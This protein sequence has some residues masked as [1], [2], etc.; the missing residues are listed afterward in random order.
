MP[1]RGVTP[2]SGRR[3]PG[4]EGLRAL[5]ACSILVYHSWVYS[6]PKGNLPA[7]GP[8]GHV[9]P[10]LSFGVVL[11]FTLS[12]FLLFRPFAAAVIRG[13]PLPRVTTYLKNRA[14]RILP[15]YWVILALTAFL[16][17]A[18]LSRDDG[19]SNLGGFVSNALLAQNY[20][21]KTLGSGIGPAW[22][23]AVEAVFYA[24]LPLLALFALTAARKAATRRGRRMAALA[25]A[26][27][28]LALGLFGK[29]VAA[30][31]VPPVR[32]FDGWEADWHSVIERSFLC[33]AD[34]FAFGMA[35]A[36]VRIDA[37]DGLLRLP[38]GWR[39]IAGGG[40]LVAY[41]VTAKFTYFSQQLSYS[42]FN[43]L[44]AFAFALLLALVVL[45]GRDQSGSHALLRF[46]ETRPLVGAGLV[47]YSI[48]LWHEPL[49]RWLQEHHLTVDGGWGF[50]VNVLAA[51]LATA[52][53]ST[54]TY[55]FVEAPAMRLKLQRRLPSVPVAASAEAL[56]PRLVEVEPGPLYGAEPPSATVRPP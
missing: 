20:D 38:R 35:L 48:F 1:M 5:A 41:L 18:A 50:G 40:A 3:I 36:V 23:L 4:I 32:P 26:A 39:A 29:G 8:L 12:G 33:Q 22:S 56:V 11:F 31:L 42:P 30:Y 13:A 9:L 21:P 54:L 49:I 17:D 27:V 24:A 15:A 55:V 34:L 28:L 6:S 51:G 2:S 14:L 44:M 16:L 43:T 7:L 10:D 46:L 37:E 25:P 53:L 45:P 47:S 52:V 19:V